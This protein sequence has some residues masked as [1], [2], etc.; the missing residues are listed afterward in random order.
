MNAIDM[1]ER[2]HREAE[3]L[4]EK[5]ENAEDNK[6]EIFTSLAQKLRIHMEIEEQIFYPAVYKVDSEEINHAREEH[7]KAKPVITAILELDTIDQQFDLL[8][9]D[10]KD[11]ITH[12]VDE[13]EADLFPK[14]KEDLSP[15]ELNELGEEM[16]DLMTELEDQ[17]ELM[18]ADE[19]RSSKITD[20]ESTASI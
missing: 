6:R 2:Q 12:H 20:E 9:A 17:S 14:C 15:D 4:F 7:A 3:T 16:Q 5:I 13:E 10:L 1:L 18:L 11:K 19:T 8:L